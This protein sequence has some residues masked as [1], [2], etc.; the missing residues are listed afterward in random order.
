MRRVWFIWSV[1]VL[2]ALGTS[3]IT[4]L[5]PIYQDTLGFSE[6]FTTLFLAAMSPPSFLPC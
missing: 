1:L 3:L 2:F 5:I 6:T 4:P